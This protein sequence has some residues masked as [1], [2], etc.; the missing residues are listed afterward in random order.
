VLFLWKNGVRFI[1]LSSRLMSRQGF[2]LIVGEA[3]LPRISI[4]VVARELAALQPI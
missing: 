1:R 3:L 4:C 2:V